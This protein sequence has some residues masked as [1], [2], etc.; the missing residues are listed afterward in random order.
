MDGLM[1]SFVKNKQGYRI[2]CQRNSHFWYVKM[3]GEKF[4][5]W[6]DI[7]KAIK[8]DPIPMQSTKNGKTI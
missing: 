2:T 8:L 7:Q 4:H 3:S 6:M 1:A 5:E